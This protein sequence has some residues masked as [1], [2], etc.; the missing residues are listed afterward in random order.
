M[1]YVICTYINIQKFGVR[2]FIII[3]IIKEINN[4]TQHG[5]NKL[6]KSERRKQIS[7]LLYK[8]KA[9]YWHL[10]PIILNIAIKVLYSRKGLFRLL[11]YISH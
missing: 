8:K 3:I 1:V 9:I 6:I 11:K 4:F 5:C 7:H 10:I 2:K